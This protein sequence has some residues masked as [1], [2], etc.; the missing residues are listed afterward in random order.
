MAE[1]L[2]TCLIVQLWLPASAALPSPVGVPSIVAVP[3]PQPISLCLGLPCPAQAWLL[4]L[5]MVLLIARCLSFNSFY[6]SLALHPSEESP[7]FLKRLS[8]QVV[9][10]CSVRGSAPG[11]TMQHAG[12]QAPPPREE[13]GVIRDIPAPSTPLGSVKE[14]HMWEPGK[15]SFRGHE[16][17]N[18]QVY[19]T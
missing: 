14:K 7:Q 3:G 15:A 6:F 1:L 10:L 4:A 2:L 12:G 16:G 17:N 8:Q 18:E 5:T 13:H 11:G 19:I 9:C